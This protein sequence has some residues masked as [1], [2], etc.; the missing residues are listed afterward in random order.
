MGDRNEC[1]T[2][3]ND[4]TLFNLPEGHDLVP[5]GIGGQYQAIYELPS[6]W[7]YAAQRYDLVEGRTFSLSVT[8]DF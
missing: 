4:G 7:G 2:H 8:C 3:V 5:G 1:Y 6:N